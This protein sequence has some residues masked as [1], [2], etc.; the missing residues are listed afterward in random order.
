VWKKL[1]RM[2]ALL[3]LLMIPCSLR[4]HFWQQQKQNNKKKSDTIGALGFATT[5]V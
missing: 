5:L 3:L 2:P 1:T 4:L